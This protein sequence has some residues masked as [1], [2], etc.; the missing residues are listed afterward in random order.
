MGAA[1]DPNH[2]SFDPRSHFRRRPTNLSVKEARKA[3]AKGGADGIDGGDPSAIDLE[4]GLDVSLCMEI[5]QTDPAGKTENYRLLVP[6][7]WYQGPG[8]PNTAVLHKPTIMERLR[9]RRPSQSQNQDAA[10]A[11]QSRKFD[12]S[13]SRSPDRE[14]GSVSPSLRGTSMDISRKDDNNN[15]NN[16]NNISHRD[17]LADL[18]ATAAGM[19]RSTSQRRTSMSADGTRDPRAQ[20]QST[21]KQ[22]Y[23]GAPP[24]MGAINGSHN[25]PVHTPDL[26]RQG[27]EGAPS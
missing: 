21:Y 10:A 4:G 8:D 17:E 26:Y 25:P 23:E 20:T 24:P 11:E 9:G 13:W 12:R 27:Y 18:Q 15:N 3:A 1:Q 19:G 16:N 22:G 2:P 6:A 7:L 5:D 14:G